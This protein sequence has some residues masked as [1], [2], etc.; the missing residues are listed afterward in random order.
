MGQDG[1]RAAPTGTPNGS[2]RNGVLT[3]EQAKQVND[4]IDR[5]RTEWDEVLQARNQ[6]DDYA[7]QEA[8]VR[9]TTTYQH[10]QVVM[11][12]ASEPSP[13]TLR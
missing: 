8:L 4:L 13:P 7:E 5:L 1:V 12:P 11:P 10:L 6:G 9:A 2:R 3:H